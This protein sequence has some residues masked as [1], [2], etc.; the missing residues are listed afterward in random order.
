MV[1]RRDATVKIKGR[2][3]A[4]VAKNLDAARRQP[5]S[6]HL[7]GADSDKF[8]Q[9][10]KLPSAGDMTFE[11]FSALPEKT[12]AQY[13]RRPPIQRDLALA[14]LLRRPPKPFRA[15]D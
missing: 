2:K 4:A 3:E 8:G 14:R 7:V 6:T 9:T 5:A 1:E 15:S 11:E 10:A 12:K 13:R